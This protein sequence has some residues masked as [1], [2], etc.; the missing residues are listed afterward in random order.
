M[1]EEIDTSQSEKTENKQLTTKERIAQMKQ[2]L[3]A[4]REAIKKTVDEETKT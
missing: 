1:I 2:S 4:K 3:Q